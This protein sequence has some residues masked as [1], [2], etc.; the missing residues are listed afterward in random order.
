MQEERTDSDLA[1]W[2]VVAETGKSSDGED[3]NHMS[4]IT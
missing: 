3:H 4:I 2:P 1:L